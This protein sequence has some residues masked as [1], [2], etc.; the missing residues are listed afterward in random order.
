MLERVR[1]AIMAPQE[2]IKFRKDKTIIAILFMMFFALFMTVGPALRVLQFSG[3]SP[4]AR[5]DIRESFNHPENNCTISDAVVDCED[6]PHELFTYTIYGMDMTV[7]IDGADSYDINRF[8]GNHVALIGNTMY[9]SG[10]QFFL[11]QQFH[12]KPI[13]SMH[14]SIHNLDLNPDEA[15]ESAFFSA[16]FDAVDHEIM[17][18]MPFWL[19]VR[20]ISEYIS[21]IVLFL[22][23]VLLNSYLIRMRMKKV[24]FKQM[25]VMMTYASTLLF[26]ILIF[27]QLMMFN[28]ILFIIL[29]FI[30]FRQTSKLAFEM[31]KRLYG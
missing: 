5:S 8:E 9:I 19:A 6:G 22:V 30:G 17:A 2:L 15:D 20:V 23:F 28:L 29:L 31:Q 18:F 13:S 24:P 3:I 4:Q 11:Q 27:N 21:A 12:E 1:T 25:F 26:I 16:V 10:D 14:A 7:Y